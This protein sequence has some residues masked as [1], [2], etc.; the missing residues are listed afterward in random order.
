VATGALLVPP[1]SPVLF[2]VGPVG[3]ATIPVGHDVGMEPRQRLVPLDGAFNFRDLGGYP[4]QDGRRTRWGR[5]FRSDTL[6][7]LTGPDVER[8]RAMGLSTIVDLR[9][10]AELDRTGRGPLGSEPVDFRHLS[11]IQDAEGEGEAV[12]VPAPAGEDLSERYLWYLDVGRRPLVDALTLLAEPAS[13]PLVFHCAAG[14]DRTGVLA[15]L[16][17]DILGVDPEVIVADYVIT[18]GRMELILGRYRSDPV[19]AERVAQV[20]PG[21]FGV[22]ETTMA[23]FLAQLHDR[24]DGARAW[25]VASGLAPEQLDRMEELLLE[26]AS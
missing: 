18:A 6:H 14:K 20:P 24:F 2:T 26:P 22:E 13:L 7:E 11:V 16:V 1:W 5:L 23:G 8:L 10:S 9:T 21:R 4:G 12:A 15:A 25:A 17:L 3:R 19:F